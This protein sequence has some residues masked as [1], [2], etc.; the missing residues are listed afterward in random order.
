[1][2]PLYPK[3]KYSMFVGYW[4]SWHAENS[5]LVEE[6]I[7]EGKNV[8]QVTTRAAMTPDSTA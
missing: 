8:N 1:M 6:K 7:K 4:Q 2:S 5:W 3:L